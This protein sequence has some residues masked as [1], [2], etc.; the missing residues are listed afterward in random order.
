[1]EL[2][3]GGDART[4]RLELE[5]LGAWQFRVRRRKNSALMEA[6]YTKAFSGE[7]VPA[8]RS[9]ISRACTLL[10]APAFVV[11]LDNDSCLEGKEDVGSDR[12][13]AVRVW[14]RRSCSLKEYLEASIVLPIRGNFLGFLG[15][16]VRLLGLS[17]TQKRVI[18][19]RGANFRAALKVFKMSDSQVV[20]QVRDREAAADP[21]VNK[22]QPPL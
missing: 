21:R 1:M 14:F 20:A 4:R 7:V 10:D 6:M 3:Q 15:K 12:G 16:R 13:A 8:M 2:A 11:D 17:G 18:L 5:E 19:S 9:A 22:R